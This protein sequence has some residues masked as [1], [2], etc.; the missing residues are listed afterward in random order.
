M[1]TNF[2]IKIWNSLFFKWTLI[3]IILVLILIDY[4]QLS[5]FPRGPFDPTNIGSIGDW[6]TGLF[7]AIA[8]LVAIESLNTTKNEINR[9][10]E[11]ELIAENDQAS[12]V[13][14]WVEPITDQVYG[15][16][17]DKSLVIHNNL[18]IPL[19]KWKVKLESFESK[20]ISNLTF[21]FIMPKSNLSISM[22]DTLNLDNLDL[23]IKSSIEFINSRGVTVTRDFNGHL[24]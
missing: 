16:L 8:I 4:Y 12:L 7:S 10:E 6:V 17:T 3:L 2:I 13:Y 11:L 23:E 5:I 24:I 19:Q 21:G 9:K 18:D 14:S 1:S 22:V 20:E 15:N